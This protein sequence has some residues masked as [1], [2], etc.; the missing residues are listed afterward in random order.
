LYS[1]AGTPTLK[2]EKSYNYEVG[3]AYTGK[4]ASVRLTGYYRN[5]ENGLDFDYVNFVYFNSGRQQVAGLEAEAELQ[6]A[7][8]LQLT[9]NYTWLAA[10]ETLQ[11][12]LTTKDTTYNYL[13]K[14]PEHKAFA[15]LR[16]KPVEKLTL[17][18]NLLLVSDRRDVGGFQ[19]ADVKLKGYVLA[20]VAAQYK[21][22]HNLT[23]FADVQNLFDKTYFDIHGYNSM[24]RNVQ[25]GLRLSL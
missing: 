18:A 23:L 14:R 24:G 4:Q 17:S 15:A 6:L 3:L 22:A 8:K 10:E 7:P 9:A 25:G 19:A 5:I 21:A 11:S 20:G 2:A 13:L 1:F 12:R 16:Y